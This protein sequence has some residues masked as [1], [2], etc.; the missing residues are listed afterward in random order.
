MIENNV[1]EFLKTIKT[2]EV[3]NRPKKD[4]NK[5]DDAIVLGAI[6]KRAIMGARFDEKRTDITRTC[7][8]CG[9]ELKDRTCDC[10]TDVHTW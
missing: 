5:Y 4:P 3:E 6:E 2:I 1:Q 7:P 8:E 9:M 10:Q